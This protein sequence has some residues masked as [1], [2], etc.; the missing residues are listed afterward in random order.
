MI[1]DA[2]EKTVGLFAFAVMAQCEFGFFSADPFGGEPVDVAVLRQAGQYFV[3][4]YPIAVRKLVKRAIMTNANY[5]VAGHVADQLRQPLEDIPGRTR[6]GCDWAP[7]R[8]CTA[9][10]TTSAGVTIFAFFRISSPGVTAFSTYL[11]RNETETAN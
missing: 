3:E 4:A 6:G 1:V 10:S 2:R 5:A 8:T 7:P 11:I 9:P